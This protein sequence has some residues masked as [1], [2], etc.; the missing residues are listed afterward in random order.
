[1]ISPSTP[2]AI[3]LPSARDLL[4][5][6]LSMAG[7]AIRPMVRIPG[8]NPP[9][10]ASATHTPTE[11]MARPPLMPESHKLSARNRRSEIPEWIKKLPIRRNRGMVI[12]PGSVICRYVVVATINKSLGPPIKKVIRTLMPP[13]AKTTGTPN[14]KRISKPPN[15][16]TVVSSMLI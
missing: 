8:P 14:A 6:C 1:M 5:R 7:T 15:N 13:S 16:K 3:T 2:P 10:M 9:H 11:T 4:Y 12:R